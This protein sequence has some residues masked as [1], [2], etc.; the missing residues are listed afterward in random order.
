MWRSWYKTNF[1]NQ[2][3]V[4]DVH[5]SLFIVVHNNTAQCK[6]LIIFVK[7]NIEMTLTKSIS[8]TNTNKAEETTWLIL[9]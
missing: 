5:I 2:I 4:V 3:R 1:V 9:H 8:H 6:I 7:D